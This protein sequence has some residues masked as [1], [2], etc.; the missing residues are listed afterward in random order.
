MKPLPL[1]LSWVLVSPCA[2]A[3][4]LVAEGDVFPGLGTVLDVGEVVVHD[5][6][7]W[8]ATV[9]LSGGTGGFQSLVVDGAVVAAAG[10]PLPGLPTGSEASSLFQP[11]SLEFDP[12]GRLLW[13]ANGLAS[14][15]GTGFGTMVVYRDLEPIAVEGELVGAA[16]LNPSTA[17]RGFWQVRA[18]GPDQALIHAS[19][20]DPDI[21]GI[22]DNHLILLEGAPGSSIGATRLYSRGDQLPGLEGQVQQFGEFWEGVASNA[23]GEVLY[24]VD[25]TESES[26]LFLDDELLAKSGEA[27]PLFAELWGFFGRVST[28][29]N[30]QG[31]YAFVGRT[32]VPDAASEGVYWNG[33]KVACLGDS[34]P[35][36]AP[37]AFDRFFLLDNTRPA[38]VHLDANGRVYWIAGWADSDPSTD[39]GIFVDQELLLREGSTFVDGL[40]VV[41]FYPL[42][43]VTAP[44]VDVS[45]SGRFIGLRAEL[46]DGRRAAIRVQPNGATL[47]LT[48]CVAQAG[49]LE[50]TSAAPGQGMFYTVGNAP[51]AGALAFVGVST[52]QLFGPG[53]CGIDLPGAGELQVDLAPGALLVVDE[54]LF[55]TFAPATS[56]PVVGTPIPDNPA[57]AGFSIFVQGLWI[58]PAPGTTEPL[59][60]TNAVELVIGT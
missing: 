15:S 4:V 48:P 7:R 17:Y 29:L 50:V 46:E 8:A 44:I 31:D 45:Q 19:A 37:F 36:I 35:D 55:P 41:D 25:S 30:D 13:V 20:D 43:G 27:S 54:G 56:A 22:T 12:D 49:T 11:V 52:A 5:S 34:L 14:A 23:N 57:L 38:S 28:A 47:P 21:F 24:V 26:A 32:F 10:E 40:R 16:G 33:S 51:Q 42:S 6:G 53:G 3:Q 60:L 39:L 2:L 18:A 1:A 58:D 59:R 9:V